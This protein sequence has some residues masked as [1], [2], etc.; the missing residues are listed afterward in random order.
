MAD[1]G[2]PAFYS[3]PDD[4]QTKIDE[5]FVTESVPTVSGLSVFLGFA[6]RSSLYDQKARGEDFSY[7]IKRAVS[8]IESMHEKALFSKESSPAGSIFWLKNYGWKDKQETDASETGGLRIVLENKTDDPMFMSNV[9]INI[10]TKEKTPEPPGLVR[11]V[12]TSA[13]PSRTGV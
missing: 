12:S 13:G 4:L 1:R 5:Y 2:R 9:E 7:P 10:P 11:A 6:D 3:T 8:I